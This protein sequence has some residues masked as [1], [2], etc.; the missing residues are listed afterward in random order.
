MTP[1][2]I[3]Y[4]LRIFEIKA[5]TS[6][7]SFGKLYPTTNEVVSRIVG[8]ELRERRITLF[9]KACLTAFTEI[10]SSSPGDLISIGIVSV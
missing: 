7:R 10:N 6:E 8:K 9:S 4:A 1:I 2:T 3:P 5:I